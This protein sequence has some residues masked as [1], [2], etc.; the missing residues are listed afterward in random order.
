MKKFNLIIAGSI[1][2]Y[3]IIAVILGS[4]VKKMSLNK[5]KEYKVE[6]NRIYKSLSGGESPDGLDLRS[7]KFIQRVIFLPAEDS[8]KEEMLMDFYEEEDALKMEIKPVFEG[9]DLRGFVRFDYKEPDVNIQSVFWL[10]QL[11]LGIMELSALT[12][13]FYL[14]YRLIHPFYR[15]SSLPYELSRGHF[16]S[17]VKEDKNRFFGQFLWGLSQL[18]DS[19][20]V[21]RKRQ[22]ELEKEKKKLLLSLSHDIKTPVQT[23]KLY[24]KALEEKLYDKEEQ[25]AHAAHQIGEKALEIE[26]Y[27]EEIMKNS[28]EDILDIQVK[29]ESF[30]Q[31]E[32]IKQILD[33]YQEKCRIR[34]VELDVGEYNNI[35]LKGDL[36][37]SVE[38]F[39]NIFENAFKYGDGR[40]IEISF[41]EEEFCH[42][43]RIYN[44]GIPVSDNDFNHMFES[45]FRASNSDGQPGNG[46]GL[47][48][49][50]EIM[51]K[52]GGEIF[53][54]K[55]LEGMAFV[56]VFR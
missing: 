24:S 39:E 48:I 16:K 5:G 17:L 22:L 10:S 28:R 23:I 30:Y 31:G 38:V 21:S 29:D 51:R 54:Q 9:S 53:A 11:C 1:L 3:F 20:E 55:D 13:L 56:L 43:I 15:M 44:T 25:K 14:K 52:M 12:V 19:L 37:R 33:T 18:K 32:L 6:I 27:V 46:L 42:L 40:R 47:Y 41:S 34:M 49:C 4:E 50:R 26:H 2:L 7:C 36:D 8:A 45:F 35:L